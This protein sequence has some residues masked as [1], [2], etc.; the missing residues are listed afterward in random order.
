MHILVCSDSHGRSNLL[1][2]MIK[3]NP[4]CNTIFFL[5]DGENDL[6]KAIKIFPDKKFIYVLGNCD[7]GDVLPKTSTVEYQ[8]IEGSTIVATHGHE[9]YVKQTTTELLKHAEGVMANVAFYG[10]THRQDFRYDSAYK[11][12]LLNPGALCLGS[13]AKVEVNKYGIEAEFKNVFKADK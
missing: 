7:W 1:V 5:G 8:H 3:Q 13:Y 12:F 9:F 10:H 11:I 4:D 6:S 2:D